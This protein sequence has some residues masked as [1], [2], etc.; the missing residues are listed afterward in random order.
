MRKQYK[1][2]TLDTLDSLLPKNKTTTAAA[3]PLNSTATKPATIIITTIRAHS[4]TYTFPY[5]HTHTYTFYTYCINVER[6]FR[7]AKAIIG[8]MAKTP[9][10]NQQTRGKRIDTSNEYNKKKED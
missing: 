1:K 10:I 7:S 6:Q 9:M 4:S 2:N 5:I 3:A 8:K